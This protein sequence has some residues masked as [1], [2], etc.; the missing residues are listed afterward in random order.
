MSLSRATDTPRLPMKNITARSILLTWV[1][2]NINELATSY[3]FG[4]DRYLLWR[5]C[6]SSSSNCWLVKAVRGLRVLPSKAWP[7]G[8]PV[9]EISI[10]VLH[11]LAL[12]W[13]TP[14]YLRIFFQQQN[15]FEETSENTQSSIYRQRISSWHRRFSQPLYNEQ[16]ND[17]VGLFTSTSLVPI[18]IHRFLKICR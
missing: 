14:I 17:E 5:N 11:V 7:G 9:A 12:K 18:K 13:Y 16:L 8:W 6:F 15:H 1:S 4:R 3:L 2:V 10:N